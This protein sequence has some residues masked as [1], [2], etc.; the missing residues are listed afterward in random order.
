MFVLCVTISQQLA[1]VSGTQE[2]P[3][4]YLFVERITSE[5]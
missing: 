2:V 4:T 3:C 5:G 1:Q